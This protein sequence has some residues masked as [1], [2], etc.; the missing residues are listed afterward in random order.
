MEKT[1]HTEIIEFLPRAFGHLHVTGEAPSL[2]DDFCFVNLNSDKP[3]SFSQ[4]IMMCTEYVLHQR[5]SEMN[6]L[7]ASSE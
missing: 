6:G 3:V 2:V 7:K 4:A 5:R 1:R